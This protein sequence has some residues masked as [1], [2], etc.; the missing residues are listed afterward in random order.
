MA[1]TLLLYSVLG[2][3][4]LG[5]ALSFSGCETC[6]DGGGGNSLYCHASSCLASE[7][8]C[9]GVCANLQSDPDNCGACG[10]TCG[11][12]MS[13]YSGVCAPSC[14]A[15]NEQSCSGVCLD[16]NSDENHCGN[17]TTVCPASQTCE[18]GTCGCTATQVT[19]GG[20]CVDP[21]TDRNHCGATGDCMGAN[22]GTTCPA[23]QSCLG[24]R[25]L[26]TAIYRGSLP[27][28]TGFWTYAG[29][30][31][32]EGATNECNLRV[33]GTGSVTQVCTYAQLTAAQAAGELINAKDYA[34]GTIT[35]W[36]VNDATAAGNLQCNDFPNF[37]TKTWT[38]AT[39]HIGYVGKATTL[40]AA[41][42]TVSPVATGNPNPAS[43][44]VCATPRAIPCCTAP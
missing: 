2:L 34:G 29:V 44:I 31:G 41:A 10:T 23:S 26:S 14:A 12:G 15:S 40:D 19:C 8:T 13:C 30:V 18:A 32:V 17:C 35:D 7:A 21:Q 22:A 11:D 1:K 36:W 38:Y 37:G 9:N 39:A 42:G 5:A 24:G 3:G 33:R 4:A 43:G 28:T 20:T 25:C 16:T 27:N 6:P